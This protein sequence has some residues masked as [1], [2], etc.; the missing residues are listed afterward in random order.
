MLVIQLVVLT[1]ETNS[2]D[3][4]EVRRSAVAPLSLRQRYL[5]D[6]RQVVVQLALDHNQLT[7]Q[8]IRKDP[9]RYQAEGQPKQCCPHPG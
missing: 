2:L 6:F 4:G 5:P 8:S 7:S 1:D 9:T 3:W